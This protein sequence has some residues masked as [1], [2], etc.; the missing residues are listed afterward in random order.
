MEQEKTIG[1]LLDQ[2]N[3]EFKLVNIDTYI[4]DGQLLLSKVL[5]KEKLWIITN[6]DKKVSKAKEKEFL[7]LVDKRKKKMPMQYILGTCE[8]MGL[9]FEVKEGV[10]I[11]R[12]DTE[13]LVEEALKYISEEEQNICDLCCGSGAIGIALA[14]Y[15]KNINV[16]LIDI[17]ATPQEMTKKNMHKFN[18]ID[19]CN[20]IKSDLLEISIKLNK[21]YNIIVSNPPYIKEDVIETLMD[22]VKKYEPHL[23]LSGGEDGLTFYRKIAIDSKK[24][25]C[26]EGILIF[27]IGHD[28]GIEVKNIM[29][30]N[31]YLNIRIIKDL[32]GL[33]RVV[34]GNL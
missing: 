27:E 14:Y 11:P 30:E 7:I 17:G 20:F 29:K 24:V 10:L 18:L 19:R 4:L 33:D 8:F 26:E 5:N 23:A 21:K 15:K 16:D 13:I 3:K 28:Q 25:L 2:V 31:G 32:A 22:D 6:R 12:G 34:I 1:Q 9:D